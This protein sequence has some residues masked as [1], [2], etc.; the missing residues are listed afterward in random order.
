MDNFDT[1]S[2]KGNENIVGKNII[3]KSHIVI[4]LCKNDKYGKITDACV[5]L[6]FL[7]VT[8][9]GSM[10]AIG[11]YLSYINQQNLELLIITFI[12]ISFVNFI[13]GIVLFWTMGKAFVYKPK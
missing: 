10:L 12:T 4:K 6:L 3:Y 9:I 5:L 11:C 8:F 13:L 1:V 7:L 2:L